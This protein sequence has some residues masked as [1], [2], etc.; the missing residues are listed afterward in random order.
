MVQHSD[1]SP[2]VTRKKCIGCGECVEH[3]AQS[4]ITL[5]NEKAEIN[6]DKVHW[7]R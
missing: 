6:G 7:V 2:K 5:K 4:A 3:C 1:L